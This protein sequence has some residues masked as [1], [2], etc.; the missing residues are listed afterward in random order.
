[1]SAPINVQ[2]PAPRN[3]AVTGDSI[4]V[5]FCAPTPTPSVS[6]FH[7]LWLIKMSLTTTDDIP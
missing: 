7:Y 2:L 4:S 6:G 1:M 3:M 5:C